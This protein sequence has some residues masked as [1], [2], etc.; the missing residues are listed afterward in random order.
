MDVYFIKHGD[1]LSVRTE[2]QDQFR[3]HNIET[4]PF[5]VL[6]VLSGGVNASDRI[7]DL[8]Q[9]FPGTSRSDCKSWIDNCLCELAGVESSPVDQLVCLDQ[10]ERIAPLHIISEITNA[11]NMHCAYCYGGFG[12]YNEEV[13]EKQS[14]LEIINKVDLCSGH[15]VQLL[16]ITGGEPSCHPEVDALITSTSGRFGLSYF[17]NLLHLGHSTLSA[18]GRHVSLVRVN[19]SFDSHKEEI[20]EKL[21]GK[22]HSQRIQNLLRLNSRELPVTINIGVSSVN[23]DTVEGSID[24]FLNRIPHAVIRVGRINNQGRA[25]SLGKGVILDQQ[26]YMDLMESIME[27]HDKNNGHLV[28]EDSEPQPSTYRCNAGFGN[29]V[30]NSKGQMKPCQRPDDFFS[31]LNS[32]VYFLPNLLQIEKNEL[33]ENPLFDMARR[34]IAFEQLVCGCV[35]D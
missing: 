19:V 25:S 17:T 10:G 1:L 12:S 30:I 9:Q 21:R 3:H 22:G 32:S 4:V 14:W 33:L 8:Q 31:S 6:R 34:E 35:F 11:C 29:I 7:S 26:R 24:W 27:R 15:P 16:N 5:D 20:D 18:L 13:L 2:K 23:V 28:I